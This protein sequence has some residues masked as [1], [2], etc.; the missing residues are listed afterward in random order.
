[1]RIQEIFAYYGLLGLINL[2]RS[3]VFNRVITF[4]IRQYLILVIDFQTSDVA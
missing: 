3:L 4:I 1:M 2:S